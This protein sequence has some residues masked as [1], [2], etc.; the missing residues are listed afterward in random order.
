MVKAKLI[1]K[2][3]HAKYQLIVREIDSMYLGISIDDID[4]ILTSLNAPVPDG[5]IE[6]P[7]VEEA[8]KIALNII[9]KVAKLNALDEAFFIAGFQECI[10]YLT[11]KTPDAG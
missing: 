1:E 3:N 6:L 8:G 2:L 9:S 7:S 11:P 4:L 5:N 10:K